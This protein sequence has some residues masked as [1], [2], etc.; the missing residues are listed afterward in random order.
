MDI[1]YVPRN[2]ISQMKETENEKWRY[3]W[4]HL[5]FEFAHL[6]YQKDLWFG[7]KYPSEIGSFDEDI[8]QYFDDL[9]LHDNYEYQLKEN[10]IS[11]NELIIVKEFHYEFE[12]FLQISA[13][14]DIDFN[15][16]SI[17]TNK[18]W[19]NVCDHGRIAWEKLKAHLKKPHE[20]KHMSDLERKYLDD[21]N[22]T[23]TRST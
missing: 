10:I 2:K 1:I 4:L 8:C 13:K 20:L 7:N 5:I 23:K 17:I 15:N 22:Q 16:E 19:I 18:S 3:T 21:K 14:L 6:N 11:Q 9:N 12:K